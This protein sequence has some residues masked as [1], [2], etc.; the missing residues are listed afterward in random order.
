MDII[1]CKVVLT[2]P[3][4][5]MRKQDSKKVGDLLNFLL[6]SG[7][8]EYLPSLQV[9]LRKSCVSDSFAKCTWSQGPYP[10]PNWLIRCNRTTYSSCPVC[11]LIPGC[12]LQLPSTLQTK[13]RQPGGV[14]VYLRVL[15]EQ[16][17]NWPTVFVV[18][19]NYVQL[20]YSSMLE[21]YLVLRHHLDCLE[22][23][24]RLISYKVKNSLTCFPPGR[25]KRQC[26]V[27]SVICFVRQMSYGENSFKAKFWLIASLFELMTVES[28][29]AN[30]LLISAR[31]IWVTLV[32]GAT[33]CQHNMS[34]DF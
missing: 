2:V 13:R 3:V 28:S 30:L 8:L 24:L 21:I 29:L 7:S 20:S 34:G 9:H 19:F 32:D 6:G 22:C 33:H 18:C 5:P 23:I 27:Q 11:A 26:R 31:L 1:L 10:M 14:G 25:K 15:S 17:Q 12:P 4:S 16:G